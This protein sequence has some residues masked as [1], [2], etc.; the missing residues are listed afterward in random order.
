MTK[1][2]PA[3]NPRSTRNSTPSVSASRHREGSSRSRPRSR[4]KWLRVPAEITSN[5]TSCSAAT[6]ATSAWVPS[7]P[8][9]PNRSAPPATAWRANAPTSTGPGPSNSTTCAPRASA[10]SLSPNRPTF[11]P[12]DRGFM[13]RYGLLGG[14][15]S[16]S[17]IRSGATSPANAARPTT[18]A[19]ISSPTATTTTH[20]S[21]RL[22][23]STSTTSGAATATPTASQRTRPLWVNAHHTPAAATATPTTPATVTATLARNPIA[24]SG[25]NT[26][27][28]TATT[29]NRASHRWATLARPGVCCPVAT[30]P[31]TPVLQQ[32]TPPRACTD[33][34]DQTSPQTGEIQVNPGSRRAAPPT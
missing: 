29:A 32:P 28:T 31:I 26:A 9:T 24:T 12:P 16:C 34:H 25:T 5:G 11:P 27:A 1:G 23:Y 18:T 19:K 20:N 21:P 33:N 22:V 8:A 10:L 30:I 13:I 15:A 7:P 2:R 3:I 14:G 6:A 17:R 4:A